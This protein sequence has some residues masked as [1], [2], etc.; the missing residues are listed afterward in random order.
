MVE[1][2]FQRLER[3]CDD[4]DKGVLRDAVGLV[5]SNGIDP[6][7]ILAILLPLRPGCEAVLAAVL[8][9]VYF[10]DLVND[11]E[12]REKFGE[13]VLQM[14]KSGK[15]LRNLDYSQNDRNSQ[16]EVLRKMFVVMAKDLR[17]ILI[18]LAYR[19]LDLEELE[20]K[21]NA[22]TVENVEEERQMFAKETLDLYVPIANRLGVYR[23]K[24][25]L[26]DLAFKHSNPGE[27]RNIV[28][29]LNRIRGKFKVSISKIKTSLEK[30]F[31]ARGVEA[32]VYGRIKGIYSIHKKLQR[33]NLDSV[34][35]LY[36]IFAMRVILPTRFDDEGGHQM[37]HLYGVL[38]MLHSEWR[39]ISKRFKDYLA[40]P[41][42]NGY[43]SLHTV[44]LGLSPK[45]LDK[46]IEVQIRDAKMH[47]DAEYGMSSHWLYKQDEDVEKHADWLK[48]L[49]QARDDEGELELKGSHLCTDAA[50]RSERFAE[51]SLS[52]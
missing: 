11:D 28:G 23:L 15:K 9:P 52:D 44:L 38:G 40:V 19:L 33:K 47:R 39:P 35:D 27:Y 36:D 29:Q 8:Q 42:P 26:E 13:V 22:G 18:G 3:E 17:V 25:Q 7:K 16:L 37:D 6:E 34:N 45:D 51:R 31:A 14:L 12:I 4:F 10:Q 41:K 30:F 2:I 20:L 43:R 32:E 49:T 1:N 50:W 5:E 24:T 46:P 21:V 48:G